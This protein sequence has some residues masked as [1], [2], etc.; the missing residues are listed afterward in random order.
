MMGCDHYR[1][2]RASTASFAKKIIYVYGRVPG[3]G[4]TSGVSVKTLREEFPG[5]SASGIQQPDK[6][7]KC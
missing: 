3:A 4:V 7:G 1:N 5:T 6:E 2:L